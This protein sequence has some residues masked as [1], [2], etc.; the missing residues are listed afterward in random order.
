VAG[1][2]QNKME[3]HFFGTR[4]ANLDRWSHSFAHRVGRRVEAYLARAHTFYVRH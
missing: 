2:V 4:Q 3:V 1:A